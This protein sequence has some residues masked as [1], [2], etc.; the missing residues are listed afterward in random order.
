[1]GTTLIV[2]C[3]PN[4][5]LVINS[6]SKPISLRFILIYLFD[7][8][9]LWME[10]ILLKMLACAY[11]PFLKCVLLFTY[12]TCNA[13]FLYISFHAITTIHI[14]ISPWNRTFVLRWIACS[15]RELGTNHT[16][17]IR[18]ETLFIEILFINS[19]LFNDTVSEKR[20]VKRKIYKWSWI[21][22]FRFIFALKK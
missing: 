22:L 7:V 2:N 4:S 19:F 10:N 8:H 1:M 5:Y 20:S 21:S 12:S 18:N 17:N 14:Y 9:C 16:M 15:E 13:V 6:I 3:C 11:S